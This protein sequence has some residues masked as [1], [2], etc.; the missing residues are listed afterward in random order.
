MGTNTPLVLAVVVV[1]WC[2]VVSSSYAALL[3]AKLAA[4]KKKTASTL[5]AMLGPAAVSELQSKGARMGKDTSATT[6]AAGATTTP[7]AKQTGNATIN[8]ASVVNPSGAI[9]V[10]GPVTDTAKV[11]KVN[12]T[13]YGPDL[14]HGENRNVDNI[15]YNVPAGQY[16]ATQ[17][18]KIGK[19]FVAMSEQFMKKGFMG[20]IIRIKGSKSSFDAVVVDLLPDRMDGKNVQVDV[21]DQKDWLALGGDAA[22]GIQPITI[23]V[24]GHASIPVSEYSPWAPSKFGPYKN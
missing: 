18:R 2:S 6:P 7:F 3:V 20:A 1:L 8:D 23:Q 13:Y 24:V 10:A 19:H 4:S 17:L 14:A 5:G 12:A 15:F 16:T 9:A 21:H 22:I 11:Y